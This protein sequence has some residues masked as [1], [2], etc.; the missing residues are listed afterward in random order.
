MA[1]INTVVIPSLSQAHT[2]GVAGHYIKS[3]DLYLG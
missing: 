3:R 1:K 2:G